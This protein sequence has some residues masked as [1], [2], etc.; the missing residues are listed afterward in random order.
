MLTS[1]RQEWILQM[2]KGPDL[3]LVANYPGRYASK[4]TI[5]IITI[6]RRQV[7]VGPTDV[8][9]LSNPDFLVAHVHDREYVI[10]WDG[11]SNLEFD[12]QGI[13]TEMA[14]PRIRAARRGLVP[15]HLGKKAG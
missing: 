6:D 10:P 15:L 9:D 11:I 5:N 13:R 3:T 2:I 1:K 4:G 12:E 8:L 14:Q 7:T